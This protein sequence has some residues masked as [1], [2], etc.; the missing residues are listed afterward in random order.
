MPLLCERPHPRFVDFE[1]SRF[2]VSIGR[3]L[4]LAS[5]HLPF[6][7]EIPKGSLNSR[8]LQQ[9]YGCHRI[10]TVQFA[11]KI[12]NLREACARMGVD[13][14]QPVALRHSAPK[15]ELLDELHA[16]KRAE[17]STLAQKYGV[18]SDGSKA[19]IIQRLSPL[20]G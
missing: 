19:D 7:A 10:E 13:L 5:G 15:P 3:G 4:D 20:L 17:L 9:E 18:S 6:G 8:A 16:M 12:P 11:Q 14:G 1:T 2:V